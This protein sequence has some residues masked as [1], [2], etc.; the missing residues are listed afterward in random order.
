MSAPAASVLLLTWNQE[1][2]AADALRS[3]LQQDMDDLEIV[4]SDD[5]SSDRTWERLREVAE[6]YRG[7]K[8]LLMLRGEKNLGIVGNLRSAAGRAASDLL[9]IAHGDDIALPNR[10]SRCLAFRRELGTQPQLVAADAFDMTQDGQ[11]LGI[12]QVDDLRD[13]SIERWAVRRPFV[14]GAAQLVTRSLLEMLPL[15]LRLS[16][17]DQC[18]GFRAVMLGSAAR[19]PEPL[20]RHRRGG[21]SQ[22]H[23][24][25]AA[26]NVELGQLRRDALHGGCLERVRDGLDRQER[27]NTYIEQMLDGKL[28]VARRA[29]RCA[30]AGIPW[31]KRLRFLAW[32]FRGTN[33]AS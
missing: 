6:S 16:C 18:L 13:W 7:A 24:R 2:F 29:A 11:V 3:L 23:V 20:I 19:I 15:D 22:L 14:L 9:F 8:R 5:A 33:R 26:A 30:V 32:S 10:C 31:S 4:V 17:E 28:G 27:L 25:D 1:R 12:K 21:L